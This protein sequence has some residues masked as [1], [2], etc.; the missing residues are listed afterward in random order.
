MPI[1]VL[2]LNNGYGNAYAYAYAYT[3]TNLHWYMPS[4]IYGSRIGRGGRHVMLMYASVS[5]LKP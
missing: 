4:S 3:K 5:S 2:T 1:L